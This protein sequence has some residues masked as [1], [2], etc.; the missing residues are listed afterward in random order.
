MDFNHYFTNEELETLLPE[1]VS[2]HPG[3][4]SLRSIGESYE[5]RPI[6]LLTLTN[7]S[8]GSDTEKPAVWVDANIHAT[9][10]AGTTTA[11]RIIY[12]LLE[13]YGKDE[14]ITRLLDHS[15]F[16]IVPRVNPDGAALAM[17][18]QP[19]YI[20]SGVRAYPWPEKEEGLHTQDVDGDGR[21]LQIRIQDPNG[22]WKISSL[23]PRLMEKRSPTEFGGT[24]YRL[25]PE[26]LIE[27]YDGY[28]IKVARQPEGLDFNRNFPFQWRPE[29]EQEGAGP[30]PASEPEIK[31]QISLS[32][33]PI[34]T[35]A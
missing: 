32:L 4:T 25:L 1:L 35:W 14:R 24:Y 13:G 8:N 10:I 3:L 23:D 5:K 22:D 31:A 17:A 19:R 34:S 29:G 33:I 12:S 18:P 28:L 9:E 21:I 15:A 27:D 2:T 30:Y 20:R 26:G 16:Y 11:L 6:W 7:T